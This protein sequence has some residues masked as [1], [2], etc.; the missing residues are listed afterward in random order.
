MDFYLFLYEL[1]LYLT[2]K[3][4]VLGLALFSCLV[5][6]V[7][8]KDGKV[9]TS[10]MKC[11]IKGKL[12]HDTKTNMAYLLQVNGVEFETVDSAAVKDG[13]FV[14]SANMDA[15]PKVGYVVFK[16]LKTIEPTRVFLD[17]DV[18]TLEQS[19]DNGEIV[20]KGSETNEAYDK[21]NQETAEMRNVMADA[22]KKYRNSKLTQEEFDRV[23]KVY[24][25]AEKK[26][27]NIVLRYIKDNSD[28]ILGFTLLSDN[29]YNIGGPVVE[30]YLRQ[31]PEMFRNDAVYKKMARF[32][33]DDK[34]CLPGNEYNDVEQK[35]PEGE[36]KKL[37]D[38]VKEGK[39]TIIDFWASWC[40]PCRAEMPNMVKIYEDFRNDGV[41][42]VG[43]SL[44][45]DEAAWK[46]GIQD[47][48]MTWPQLSDLKFWQSKAAEVYGV[49]SIPM[50]VIVA[51]NGRIIQK[52][53]RGKELYDVAAAWAKK[54]R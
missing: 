28:N 20:I 48:N 22:V 40:A 36:T 7:G 47:M 10:S 25:E 8:A 54:L 31:L 51:P 18:L 1:K 6:S 21:L 42:I 37:S 41:E 45:K 3:G 52:N 24:N 43:I 2:M 33:E 23:E 26:M 19:K 13:K 11:E 9:R 29:Y 38:F 15:V 16:D 17:A 30:Q 5:V 39:L 4:F 14:L 53:V 35:T 50:T 12:N 44:D 27:K 32:V 46:K 49:R 34:K